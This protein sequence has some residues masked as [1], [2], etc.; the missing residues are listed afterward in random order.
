MQ[1]ISPAFLQNTVIPS[2]YT[3][4]EENI[5]PPLRIEGIK[6][7]VVSLVLIMDDPDIPAAAGVPVWDHWVVFNIPPSIREIP[8]HWAVQG[9]RGVGTRNSLDYSGPKPPDREHRYFF[10]VYA[11]DAM[12]DL[13]EGAT[14]LEV[15]AAM[16]GHILEQAVLMGLCAPI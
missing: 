7:G 2:K 13:P 11:L 15:E 14:K 12:L 9:M 3:Q 8:E 6:E 10:K 4:F 5:N 16:Q 1:I